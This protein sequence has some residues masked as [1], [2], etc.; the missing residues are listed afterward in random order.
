MVLNSQGVD[1]IRKAMLQIFHQS[2][3]GC[4]ICM[5]QTR[6]G[7]FP[8]P[9]CKYRWMKD[10]CVARKQYGYGRCS[11]GYRIPVIIK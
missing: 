2:P 11:Y 7:T 5:K 4:D 6:F 10:E 1:Q 8:L 9:F 3:G